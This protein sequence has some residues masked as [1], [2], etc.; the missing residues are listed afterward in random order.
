MRD[1]KQEM[2]DALDTAMKIHAD[3]KKQEVDLLF[4]I[5]QCKQSLFEMERIEKIGH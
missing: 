5:F 3:M 1:L 2:L 4:R